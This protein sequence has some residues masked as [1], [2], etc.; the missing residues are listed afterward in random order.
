MKKTINWSDKP[1]YN[2]TGVIE[3]SVPIRKQ[4]GKDT[5]ESFADEFSGFLLF[6]R[7]NAF[8]DEGGCGLTILPRKMD[9]TT[10]K[11]IY[12]KSH[13]PSHSLGWESYF[14]LENKFAFNKFNPRASRK[15][16][17]FSV[18]VGAKFPIK[19]IIDQIGHHVWMDRRIVM[20][21]KGIQLLD[22]DA[23]YALLGLDT[24]AFSEYVV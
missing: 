10:V 16:I 21:W 19:D 17:K 1:T 18:T 6:T 20:R 9:S 8:K 11:H 5:M 24:K 13:F 14:E 22:T 7:M 15:T 23:T 3:M 12:E 4:Q 2:H